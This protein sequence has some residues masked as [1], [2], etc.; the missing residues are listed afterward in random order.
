MAPPPPHYL[1]L[2][3]PSFSL[4][5]PSHL[6]HFLSLVPPLCLP[7][8]LF[9]FH[10]RSYL[11]SSSLL[12]ISFSLPQTPKT[13]NAQTLKLICY[14]YIGDSLS[15]RSSVKSQSVLHPLHS[16]LVESISI[17]IEAHFT[18]QTSVSIIVCY[19]L[20]YFLF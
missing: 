9:P 7:P 17:P 10:S 2:I 15:S 4:C 18:T 13:S 16:G 14:C 19:N 1:L 8:F 11:P 12:L 5:L 6:P 3:F 20:P